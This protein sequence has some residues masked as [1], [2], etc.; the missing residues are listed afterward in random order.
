MALYKDPSGREPEPTQ[1]AQIGIVVLLVTVLVGSI[2]TYWTR[3]G[4]S[5]QFTVTL[6]S[7]RIGDGLKTG[8]D[9]RFRTL[10]IGKVDDVTVTPS[11]QQRVKLSIDPEQARALTTDV[12]PIYTA[13]S[14]FTATDIEFVPGPVRGAR[15]E[16]DRVLNVQTGTA[17]GTLTSV[18][19]QA[20]KLTSV[21]GDPEVY[22]AIERLSNDSDPYVRLLQ[23]VLPTAAELTRDQVVPLSDLL[24]HLSELV[25]GVRPLVVPVLDTVDFAIDQSGFMDDPRMFKGAKTAIHDLSKKLVL[26]IGGTLDRNQKSL[27]SLIHLLLDV[28]TPAVVSLGTIP[29]AYNRLGSL[30]TGTSD[31]FTVG[32]DGRVRLNIELLLAHAPQ[33]VGPALI[34]KERTDR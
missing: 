19:N 30:I 12:V 7:D 27:T 4:F 34:Y 10:R 32:R 17:L 13:A 15:L 23:E 29:D 25:D 2:F 11:G 21:I 8:T 16:D 31:A 24:K 26:G 6:V 33:V 20:G 5:K 18:L 28:L 22:E 3:G 1:L 9:V 14:I